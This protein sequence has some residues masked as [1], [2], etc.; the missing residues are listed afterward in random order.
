MESGQQNLIIKTLDNAPRLL[1][2][3]ADEFL[4]LAVPLFIGIVF[5]SFLL[6]ISGFAIKPLLTRLKKRYPKGFLKH[7]LY[8][9]LPKSAFSFSG[10]L[11]R[12]PPS[13]L[14]EF[15]A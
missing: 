2:W 12:V 3:S 9:I 10:T 6:M 13:H 8:W 7:R 15:I 14:R 11:K 5:G 4:L 1:F